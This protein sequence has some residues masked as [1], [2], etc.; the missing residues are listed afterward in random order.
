MDWTLFHFLNGSLAGHRMLQDAVRVFAQISI[1]LFVLGTLI[2][3]LGD[4]VG[5]PIRWRL[6]CASALLSAAIALF[7]AQVIGHVWFRQRPFTS[8]PHEVVLLLARSP[9]PSFPSDHACAA[10]AIAFA[11]VLATRSKVGVVFVVVAIAV[12]LSRILAGVHY[13]GDIG[14]GLV[15][16]FLSAVVVTRWLGTPVTRLVALVSRVLDPVVNVLWKPFVKRDN[17]TA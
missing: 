2:L 12:G 13:P 1:P 9:D 15:I 5:G 17:G 3:W 8:H 6:A 7:V 14:A 10:F 4:R 11:V 16:G